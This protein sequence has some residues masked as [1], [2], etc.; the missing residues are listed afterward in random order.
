MSRDSPFVVILPSRDGND[1]SIK[2]QNPPKRVMASGGRSERPGRSQGLRLRVDDPQTPLVGVVLTALSHE[3]D[4]P[5]CVECDGV[6]RERAGPDLGVT[7]GDG[8]AP[9]RPDDRS[10]LHGLHDL[11]RHRVEPEVPVRGGPVLV[12]DA[13]DDVANGASA[14]HEALSPLVVGLH[15]VLRVHV[16]LA[17]TTRRIPQGV[18]V[19]HVNPVTGTRHR[20][21][22]VVLVGLHIVAPHLGATEA[23]ELDLVVLPEK[24]Q[25]AVLRHVGHGNEHQLGLVDRLRLG[26]GRR[27]LGLGRRRGRVDR[28]RRVVALDRGGEGSDLLPELGELGVLR[29]GGRGRLG[30]VRGEDHGVLVHGLRAAAAGAA[31]DDPDR[32]RR[33]EHGRQVLLLHHVSLL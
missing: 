1:S 33:A 11:V 16:H 4:A 14:D 32:D 6:L 10:V 25:S 21:P 13:E 7:T 30:V 22:D 26:R 20:D 5:T 18:E 2:I 31:A 15:E 9:D 19:Q 12:G 28:G 3:G 29:V 17:G 24:D 8:V 23:C 27:G